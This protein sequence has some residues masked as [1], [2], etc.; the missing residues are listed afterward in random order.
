MSLPLSLSPY[1]EALLRLFYPASCTHCC[2]FLSI[3]ENL[4]C[5]DCQT[6]LQRLQF[7][8]LDQVE[9]SPIKP[10]SLSWKIFD[11]EGIARNLLSQFKYSNRRQILQIFSPYIAQ[12]C[13]MLAEFKSYDAIIPLP[14]DP[15]RKVER[16]YFPVE[17]ISKI[18]AKE[19]RR[20]LL[21]LL[22]K[23]RSTAPQSSLGKDERA[24]N[25]QDAFSAKPVPYLKK[26]LL[27][28]DIRTTGATAQEAAKALIKAGV[29]EV[30]LLTLAYTKGL[31]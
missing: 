6:A 22:K 12:T 5:S 23:I 3:Q 1:F 25:L 13:V 4:L 29:P 2:T 17:L 24:I 15:F 14:Q 9:I 19:L 21:S 18:V 20:P 30:D 10:I 16:E 27:V 8:R 7:S 28:D 11:Y 26:V 31:S